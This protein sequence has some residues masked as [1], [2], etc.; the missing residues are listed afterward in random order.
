M[1]P[2]QAPPGGEGDTPS[3]HPIPLGA[4]GASIVAPSARQTLLTQLKNTSQASALDIW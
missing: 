1:P 2:P 4:Y 3:P